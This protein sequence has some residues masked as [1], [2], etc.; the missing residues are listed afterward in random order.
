M[1]WLPFGSENIIEIELLHSF[2]TA[3]QLWTLTARCLSSTVG[4][5]N[6]FCFLKGT[7]VI[8]VASP[9]DDDG[10]PLYPQVNDEGS[11]RAS[12]ILI[13]SDKEETILETMD[14]IL[15]DLDEYIRSKKA[16]LDMVD[17]ELL[18]VVP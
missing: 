7:N 5:T 14:G 11:T 13:T 16:L 4:D 15:A 18:T 10:V 1:T 17:A 2:S 12:K 6:R 9:L 8:W 3:T